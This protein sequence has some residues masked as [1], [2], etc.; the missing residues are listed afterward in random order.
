MDDVENMGSGIIIDSSGYVLTSYHVVK[1]ARD[2]T[3]SLSDGNTYEGELVGVDSLSDLAVVKI[4]SDEEGFKPARFSD[5]DSLKVGQWALALGNPFLNFFKKSDPTVTVGVISALN[6]N[7]RQSESSFYQ[8]MIQTDAAINPGNS[9]GPLIN[10]HGDVIGVN[11]FIYTGEDDSHSGGSI[12]IG[13]AIPSN[14]A[15]NVARELIEYGKRRYVYTGMILYD[16]RDDA[17]LEPGVYIKYIA[18]MGPAAEAG[19][20]IGDRINAVD[21]RRIH[22]PRDLRG[23]LVPYFPGD[24]ISISVLR[25]EAIQN[26]PLVLGNM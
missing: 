7:F 25:D 13:F 6:R 24:T 23:V 12:G 15:L 14:R 9:G 3:I 16:A 8:D 22:S 1:W 10:D 5:S 20:K 17:D 19:L 4:Q 26:F 2:L 21:G 11:A 18:P